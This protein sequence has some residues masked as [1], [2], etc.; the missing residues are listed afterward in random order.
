MALDLKGLVSTTNTI[1]RL[2]KPTPEALRLA[3]EAADKELT[4]LLESEEFFDL[5]R[6]VE[7]NPRYEPAQLRAIR[8]NLAEFDK[9]I[10]TEARVLKEA[11]L[12]PRAVESL[13]K[14][15]RELHQRA[16]DRRDIREIRRGISEVRD[17]ARSVAKELNEN[18][19]AALENPRRVKGVL[20]R[21]AT[22]LGGATAI[23]VNGWAEA[24]MGQFY[25]GVSMGFGIDM[26]VSGI[27]SKE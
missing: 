9:F 8:E 1:I 23:V 16:T 6:R 11:G 15:T 17:E 21:A 2:E 19:A 5:I 18:P 24:T 13:L 4:A 12:E 20:K 25:A 26:V 3:F 10:E 22:V 7:A 27:R 14:A